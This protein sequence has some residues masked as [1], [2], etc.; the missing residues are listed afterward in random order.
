M[1]VSPA[2]LSKEKKA[3]KSAN[4]SFSEAVSSTSSPVASTSKVPIAA[5]STGDDAHMEDED[6]GVEGDGEWQSRQLA[7]HPSGS[8]SAG[9]ETSN[10]D[11]QDEDQEE[12]DDAVMIDSNTLLPPVGASH[13]Q[14]AE[15]DQGLLK[16]PALS[17]KDMQGKVE[18]QTRKVSV[19]VLSI[20]STTYIVLYH[21]CVQQLTPSALHCF[22][23]HPHHSPPPENSP[24]TCTPR[25][26]LGT[27]SSSI[28]HASLYPRHAELDSSQI[29]PHRMTPLKRDWLKIYS[30]L[31][32]E[33]GLMVRMNVNKKNIEMK[34][35][36]DPH[37]Y[38]Y[39]V[40]P[41][42]IC[43]RQQN[44]LNRLPILSFNELSTSSLRTDWVSAQKMR[45]LC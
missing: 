36:I 2:V 41:T 4:V 23:C 3:K 1:V 30:P 13:A 24:Y 42:L 37:I 26:T 6:D 35:C 18:T 15:A 31:V 14:V 19:S 43:C 21:S 22:S 12:D 40:I 11:A 33:C 8:S 17:A 7:A 44:I 45:L 20:C 10:G 32:D 27:P 16:F 9:K 28:C 34:V 25:L 29:P 5:T 39:S 38:N